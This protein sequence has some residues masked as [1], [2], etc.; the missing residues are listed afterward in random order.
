LCVEELQPAGIVAYFRVKIIEIRAHCNTPPF[1]EGGGT[2]VSM[3]QISLIL[4]LKY[5]TVPTGCNSSTLLNY[6]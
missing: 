6:F 1:P 3:S 5:A 2:H 4:T